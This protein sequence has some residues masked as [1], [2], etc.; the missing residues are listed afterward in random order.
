MTSINAGVLFTGYKTHSIKI[1]KKYR[2]VCNGSQVASE[3][4]AW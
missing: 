3:Y 2:R 1:Q 4:C